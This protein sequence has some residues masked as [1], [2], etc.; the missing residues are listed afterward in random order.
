MERLG[1]VTLT[2]GGEQMTV[3]I[4]VAGSRNIARLATKLGAFK[5]VRPSQDAELRLL[6]A[7]VWELEQRVAAMYA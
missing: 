1:E 6:K 7:R 5:S 2:V 3:T 4:P